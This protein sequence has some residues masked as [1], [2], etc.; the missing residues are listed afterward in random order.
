[1]FR[2]II[3]LQSFTA[4]RFICSLSCWL[5][6]LTTASDREANGAE[7]RLANFR[8]DVTPP[9]G[10]GP[11][12]GCMPKVSSIEHP[13]E[14]RGV[15]LHSGDDCYVIAAI[16]FCGICNTSDEVLRD[17][18]AKAAGTT[19]E[20]V[21][22]Q[23]LHQHSAPILDA[24]A[25]RILHGEGSPELAKHIQFTN[26]IAQR[27][28]IAIEG[29]LGELKT[30]TRVVGTKAIV[31]Q[32]ASNR[33][34]PQ[35]DGSIAVRASMT[36]EAD[37]RDAPEGLIDP[38]LRT[39]SFFCGDQTLVQL[40]YYA[41]HPQ[42]FYGDARI[43]WDCVGMARQQFESE[44]GVPQI[45]FTGCGGNIT[46]GKYNDGARTAREQL[47]SRLHDA[48]VRSSS[49]KPEVA[50]D[51]T[52]LKPSDV[53]WA[54]APIRFTVREDGAFNPGLLQSQL[55]PEQAFSTRLT[56]AMFSG[57]G[58]RLR[59]GYFAQAS[60]LRIGELEIMHLPGEPF[61]EFQLY[62]Q[63]QVAKS[64]FVCVAGYGECG[65]WYY[66]P[67]RIFTDR[68]GYEQTWSLTGPCEAEVKSA[69]LTLL[70]K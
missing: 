35:P 24:D 42:T 65:V 19:R 39:V 46:V 4:S 12:V 49:A 2:R 45:Y 15:V 69:I 70:T 63:E 68:G 56:A 32:V 48:M 53:A 62:A 8:V 14:L 23:S 26:E 3:L 11:C 36:R 59:D 22:L 43:S 27:T 57:F 58:Q 47:A 5:V 41:T 25:V 21:A 52:N 18:M 60:R 7:V 16:D 61:V 31:E 50:L 64:S 66:G 10:D 37:V 40:H 30:V 34:V 44:S 51:V 28:A 13:L 9:I 29:S 17:A 6:I 54:T 38:W 67:D 55:A 20:R 1:M 33:R